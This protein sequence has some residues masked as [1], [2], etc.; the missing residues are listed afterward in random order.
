MEVEYE[1]LVNNPKEVTKDILKYCGLNWEDNCLE[2][3]EKNKSSIDTASANQANK[4]IYKSS[5]NKFNYYKEFFNF[6]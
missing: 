2:Y 5:L 1:K 6:E 4:P 3:H